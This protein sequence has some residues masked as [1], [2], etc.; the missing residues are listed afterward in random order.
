MS[1]SEEPQEKIR[2]NAYKENLPS[3]QQSSELNYLCENVPKP[4][5][6]QVDIRITNTSPLNIYYYIDVDPPDVSKMQNF[7]NKV[8]KIVDGCLYRAEEFVSGEL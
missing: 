4:Y 8:D 5:S 7:L 1:L 3:T 6:Y 2:R